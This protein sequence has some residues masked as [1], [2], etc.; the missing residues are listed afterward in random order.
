[1]SDPAAAPPRILIA[2]IGNIF[3]GDDGFGCAVAKL[4]AARPL[5]DGVRVIDFG[6]RGLDLTFALTSGE[7][8]AVVLIDAAA[9]GGAAGTLYVIEPDAAE[10]SSGEPADLSMDMHNIDP[11]KVLRLA[12]AMGGDLQRVVLVACQP[13]PAGDYEEMQ[14]AMTTPVAAAIPE[15]AKLVESVVD[16]LRCGI[17]AAR[18]ET[19]A[20]TT[21]S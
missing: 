12:A 15:A 20:M 11:A 1:M 14:L 4:L 9:R 5:P 17:R 13:S 3:L 8:D 21:N 16:S 6:I 18:I 10:A 19:S 2:G 7:Y